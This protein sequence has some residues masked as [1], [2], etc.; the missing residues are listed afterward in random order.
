MRHAAARL[1]A[2]ARPPLRRRALGTP[3]PRARPTTPAAARAHYGR[4]MSTSSSQAQ[5]AGTM[6]SDGR[7]P[8]RIQSSRFTQHVV[9]AMRK[10]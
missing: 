1:L 8:M 3:P 4:A 7:G 6:A 5:P 10:L 9:D 2:A